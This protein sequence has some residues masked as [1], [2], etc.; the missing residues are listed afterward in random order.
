MTPSG[1]E[2]GRGAAISVLGLA[3]AY[4]AKSREVRVLDG[5]DLSI[6][7]GEH[8]AVSGSSGAGKTT[9]LAVL[10]GLERA[11]AGA[12]SVAGSDLLS[13]RGDEL[14]TFRR[15]TVGF[16]FQHYGLL[17]A[18]T[19][20]ENVELSGS[21]A[22]RA[23]AERRTRARELLG[24]VG[25][26]HRASHLPAQLSGGERQRV[27]IARAL[28]NSPRLVLADE[29]TGNLDEDNADLVVDLLESVARELACT[30]VV[31]THSRT[32]AARAARRFTLREGRLV[33]S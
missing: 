12:V 3:H 33:E 28:V 21:L 27:A 32:V 7:S 14:A 8:V 6:A 31:V 17:D 29:P 5:V 11:S 2:T 20:L 18:L 24:R 26:E 9:L 22:R 19:A 25:M 13:L 16:V 15:D 23:R 1:G 4:R 10:G 30:L